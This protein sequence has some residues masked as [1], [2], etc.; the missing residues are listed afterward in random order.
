MGQKT[1]FPPE[2]TGASPR[3]VL[4]G[5]KRLL[6]E[7]HRGV[8]GYTRERLTVRLDGG[9]M[10]VSGQD[11]TISEYGVR[12]IVVTGRIDGVTFS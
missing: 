8:I 1:F 6:I 10:A 12:D 2:A 4:Y 7:Q 9:Y 5:R 11:L 3:I